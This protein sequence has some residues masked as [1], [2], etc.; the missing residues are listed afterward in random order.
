MEEKK[1][2]NS[3]IG[4]T[5]NNSKQVLNTKTTLHDE[6]Q[7]SSGVRHYTPKGYPYEIDSKGRLMII[8]PIK[9]EDQ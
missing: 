4:I 9:G 5:L 2:Q 7:M 6:R 8:I 3:E 1:N